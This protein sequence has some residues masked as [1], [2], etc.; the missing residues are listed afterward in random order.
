[1]VG[2]LPVIAYEAE[3][4]ILSFEEGELWEDVDLVAFI[5]FLIDQIPDEYEVVNVG[6]GSMTVD[7]VEEQFGRH[8]F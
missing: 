5:N 3:D 8:E 6:V 7:V 1:M 4:G 2:F